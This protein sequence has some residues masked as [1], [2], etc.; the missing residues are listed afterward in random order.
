MGGLSKKPNKPKQ[1]PV[2]P[3]PDETQLARA[4]KRRLAQY[5]ANGGGTVMS[6]TL[7]G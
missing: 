3:M 6:D 1:Q 4:R 2:Y 5:Q 7:G